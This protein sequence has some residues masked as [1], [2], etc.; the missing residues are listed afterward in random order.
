MEYKVYIH[1]TVYK[2]TITKL[3]KKDQQ[4]VKKLTQQLTSSPYVGDILQIKSIREKRLN[5]KRIYYVIFEDLKTILIIAI[6]NKKAQQKTID[7]IRSN[8]N[9]YRNYVIK[10]KDD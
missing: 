4:R 1:P 2:E 5:S 10:Y 9:N 6:S 7:S 3:P 8:L